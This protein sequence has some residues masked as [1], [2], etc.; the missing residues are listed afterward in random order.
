MPLMETLIIA[1]AVTA[2][3]LLVFLARRRIT[4]RI[5]RL[6]N[7]LTQITEEQQYQERVTVEGS[8]EL[9]QLETAVNRM[10][11][12]L[13]DQ[14]RELR[15]R[16]DLFRSLAES[17]DAAIIV[18][19]DEILYANGAAAAICGK[20]PEELEGSSV[21]ELVHPDFRDLARDD[22]LRRLAGGDV[23]GRWELQLL[24]QE[25]R[26]HWVEATAVSIAMSE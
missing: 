12:A 8:G 20:S 26:G 5:S 19:S 22:M 11:A 1:S 15:E 6:N 7:E 17:L 25:G 14:G 4:A 9:A 3:V 16:E 13:D 23:P 18:H 2:F 24:D 10:F 21:F